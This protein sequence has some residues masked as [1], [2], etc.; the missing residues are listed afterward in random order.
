MTDTK[1]N[2]KHCLDSGWAIMW[3]RIGKG[4]ITEGKPYVCGCITNKQEREMTELMG[5]PTHITLAAKD[6]PRDFPFHPGKKK[7]FKV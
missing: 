4:P 6:V 3:V 1:P 2:C 7:A 5:C